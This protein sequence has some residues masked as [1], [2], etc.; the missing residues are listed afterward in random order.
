MLEYGSFL[1]VFAAALFVAAGLSDRIANAV[2]VAYV[3]RPF[4]L[5]ADIG[6]AYSV[7]PK[8][9]RE[10][11]AATVAVPLASTVA[12]LA[13]AAVRLGRRDIGD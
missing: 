8:E 3:L 1:L 6:H 12:F 7:A 13:A 5:L 2:F 10:A 4:A 11:A 9:F